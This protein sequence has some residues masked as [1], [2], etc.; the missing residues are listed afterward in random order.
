MWEARNL[1]ASWPGLALALGALVTARSL[2]RL[3]ASLVIGAFA[4]GAVKMLEEGSQRPAYDAGR[5]FIE[6]VGTPATRAGGAVALPGPAGAARG[7]GASPAS[8]TP[9]ARH[10]LPRSGLAHPVEGARA[11]ARTRRSRY[12]TPGAVAR[13]AARLAGTAGSSWSSPGVG[14]IR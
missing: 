6:R 14:D 13:D 9:D 3:L 1:T 7:R 8:L 2:R 4:I 11:P 10:V 12:R 5:A